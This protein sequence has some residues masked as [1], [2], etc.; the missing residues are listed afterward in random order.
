MACASALQKTLGT[1]FL[2]LG[3]ALH[4]LLVS[5]SARMVPS[6][7]WH[8]A[9]RERGTVTAVLHK[10]E[11]CARASQLSRWLQ[12]RERRLGRATLF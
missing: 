7:V 6:V 5:E 3:F 8:A 12:V 10:N 11:R 4:I 1:P 2:S 9:W